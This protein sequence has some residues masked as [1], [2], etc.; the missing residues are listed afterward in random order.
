VP[1]QGVPDGVCYAGVLSFCVTTA[2]LYDQSFQ[3]SSTTEVPAGARCAA[4]RCHHHGRQWP[5][6]DQALFAARA[7]HVKGVEAV[8]T[9]V[10]ACVE[11][12]VE[13]LTVFAFSPKTGAARKR[14]CRC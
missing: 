6:G 7:G 11:R 10:E 13:Y 1:Q 4:P 14:K 3:K 9:V 8:R 5:L 2:I 12:G